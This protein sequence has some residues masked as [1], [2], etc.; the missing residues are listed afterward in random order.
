MEWLSCSSSAAFAGPGVLLR[1][2]HHLWHFTFYDDGHMHCKLLG[3]VLLAGDRSHWW[4]LETTAQALRVPQG[5]NSCSC[6]MCWFV[7]VEG[8]FDNTSVVA[9][10]TVA[11]IKFRC[12]V[13][14]PSTAS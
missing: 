3:K 12:G 9:L 1:L 7:L 11:L 13:T 5:L 6:T 2:C 4:L 14:H 10:S 8:L